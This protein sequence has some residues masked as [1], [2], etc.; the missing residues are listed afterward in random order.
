[1]WLKNKAFTCILEGNKKFLAFLFSFIYVQNYF[2]KNVLLCDVLDPTNI[3]LT[4]T[5]QMQVIDLIAPPFVIVVQ[6]L[7]FLLIRWNLN[8][9]QVGGKKK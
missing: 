5:L 1:M 4:Q 7:R 3:Y 6:F 8:Y 2:Y 9:A